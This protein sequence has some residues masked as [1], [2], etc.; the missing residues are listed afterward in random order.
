[1]LPN[2]C[3]IRD[4]S[5]DCPNPPSYSVSI[6]DDSGEYMVGVVCDEHR[7][8]ME[9]MV[10][11][12]QKNGALPAGSVRFIELKSVGTDCIKGYPDD[13]QQ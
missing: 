3:S 8:H 11:E 13:E 9:R 6:R 4:R 1:M 5:G 2:R 7:Q 10:D 12:K